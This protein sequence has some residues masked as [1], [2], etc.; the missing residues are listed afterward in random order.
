M[1]I[2]HKAFS[3]MEVLVAFVIVSISLSWALYLVSSAS[4]MRFKVERER[5]ARNILVEEYGALISGPEKEKLGEGLV[6]TREKGDLTLKYQYQVFWP[7]AEKYLSQVKIKAFSP[8]GVWEN[9]RQLE[10]R[11]K[12]TF[13]VVRAEA[14]RGENLLAR[15]FF[16]APF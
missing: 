7:F 12:V 16:P 11:E 15:I 6:I 2:R 8:S 4:D 10:G 5:E 3:L 14:W 1:N 13:G 9:F